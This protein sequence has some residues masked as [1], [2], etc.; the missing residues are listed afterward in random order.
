MNVEL[1]PF[2]T[3]RHNAESA[4]TLDRD[5]TPLMKFLFVLFNNFDVFYAT[6]PVGALCIDYQERIRFFLWKYQGFVIDTQKFGVSVSKYSK[7]TFSNPDYTAGWAGSQ[8]DTAGWAAY[9]GTLQGELTHC[10]TLQGELTHGGTLQGELTHCGTLQDELTHC[11]T[12]QGEL[13]HGGTLQVDVTVWNDG[14][15]SPW[16]PYR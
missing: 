12:L 14:L 1:P 13:T 11:G 3:G 4:S 2:K 8:W 15:S 10:G 9:G 5:I 6:F 16:W 7:E